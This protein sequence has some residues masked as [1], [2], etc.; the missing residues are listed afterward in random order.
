MFIRPISVNV[1]PVDSI[2]LLREKLSLNYGKFDIISCWKGVLNEPG[3]EKSFL[4]DIGIQ[5]YDCLRAVFVGEWRIN[6]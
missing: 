2:T 5:N 6:V 1:S 3:W 4:C